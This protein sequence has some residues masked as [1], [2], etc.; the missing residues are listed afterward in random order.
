MIQRW[1]VFIVEHRSGGDVPAQSY[2]MGERSAREL[3]AGYRDLTR[4]TV[5]L[6]A[7]VDGKWATVEMKGDGMD[8]FRRDHSRIKL[9]EAKPKRRRNQKAKA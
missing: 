7:R 5:E 4:M 8:P 3:Y 9:A 1:R 2:P 6:Q